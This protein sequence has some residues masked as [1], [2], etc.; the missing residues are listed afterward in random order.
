MGDRFD[1]IRNSLTEAAG[2]N[3]RE[4]EARSRDAD[5]GIELI[6]RREK[7]DGRDAVLREARNALEKDGYDNVSHLVSTWDKLNRDDN[8]KK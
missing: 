2:L 5:R 1:D 7:D 6:D 3:D 8:L 4:E